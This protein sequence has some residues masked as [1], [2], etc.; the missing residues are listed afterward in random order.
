VVEISRDQDVLLVY[1]RL[2]DAAVHGRTVFY[3]EVAQILGKTQ[4]G[5]HMGREVGQ[6][7]GEISEDEDKEGRP[8]LRAVAISAKGYSGEGFFEL[9][10]RLRGYSGSFSRGGEGFLGV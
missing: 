1:S 9:A 10:K 7:L 5:H 8:M 4:P 3:E 6:V 2:I